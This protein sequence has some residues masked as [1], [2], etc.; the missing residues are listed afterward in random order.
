MLN[1]A[2]SADLSPPG[3]GRSGKGT[4]GTAN[5][6]GGGQAGVGGTTKTIQSYFFTPSND[7]AVQALAACYG[8]GDAAGH[9]GAVSVLPREVDLSGAD[10]DSLH[11]EPGKGQPVARLA[12]SGSTGGQGIGGQGGGGGG[13]GESD[14]G[15]PRHR[16]SHPVSSLGEHGPCQGQHGQWQPQSRAQ[17]TIL[18]GGGV[19]GGNGREDT[20]VGHESMEQLSTRLREAEALAARLRKELD[21]ANL[22]RGS[23]E[24]MVGRG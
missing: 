6:A 5:G 24:S 8:G 16:P 20:Q 9:A 11:V 23:M 13:G 2:Q 21:R 12:R 7:S 1:V 18:A 19:G 14:G 22:E 15:S 10:C 17:E 4:G 3:G